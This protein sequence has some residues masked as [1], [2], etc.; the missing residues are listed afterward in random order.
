MFPEIEHQLK[1][2]VVP[3][4]ESTLSCETSCKP[5]SSVRPI[6]VEIMPLIVNVVPVGP[7]PGQKS[8]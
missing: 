2:P 4:G 7:S 3:A 6:A 5:D 8:Q 1:E